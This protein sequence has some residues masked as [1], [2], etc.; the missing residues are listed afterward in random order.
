M[1]LVILSAMAGM[2]LVSLAVPHAFGD[3]G[4]LFGIAYFLVGV[5]HVVLYALAT[6]HTPDTQRAV[7]RLAPGLLGG[8]LY[9]LWLDYSTV[10]PRERF[11][12]WPLSTACRSSTG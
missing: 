1:R 7:L 3:N 9:S 10:W 11:G 6:G 2:L 12:P 5:F 4:V 8:P